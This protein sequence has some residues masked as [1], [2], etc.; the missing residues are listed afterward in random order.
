VAFRPKDREFQTINLWQDFA[1]RP[2]ILKFSTNGK[3]LI[4][5]YNFDIDFRLIKI[6]YGDSSQSFQPKSDLEKLVVSSSCRIET[7][8]LDDWI[9]MSNYLKAMSPADFKRQSI[10]ICDLGIIKIN[11]S[12]KETERC[13][14][15]QVEEMQRSG[16]VQWP[17]P[18]R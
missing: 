5:L 9:E 6:V 16:A 18:G 14:N 15:T 2:V 12:L 17:I 1:D 8:G 10:P 11:E 4:C 7:A 13:V 3:A